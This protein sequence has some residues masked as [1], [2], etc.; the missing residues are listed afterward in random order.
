MDDMKEK[1]K[2]QVK[3][4]LQGTERVD[5]VE[6]NYTSR[7]TCRAADWREGGI[8]RIR[9]RDCRATGFGDAVMRCERLYKMRQM[10]APV[11]VRFG[12]VIGGCGVTDKREHRDIQKEERMEGRGTPVEKRDAAAGTPERGC[13]GVD[14]AV[15]AEQRS[16]PR[17]GCKD[18]WGGR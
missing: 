9:E 15:K 18:V 16:A 1:T 12:W 13:A 14:E 6:I 2:G 5:H 10:R 8:Q 3:I 17:G 11:V 7:A 4:D